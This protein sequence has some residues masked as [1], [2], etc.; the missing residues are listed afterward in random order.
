MMTIKNY[1]RN[2]FRF[3]L[4]MELEERLHTFCMFKTRY[5]LPFEKDEVY[6]FFVNVIDWPKKLPHCN[7]IEIIYDDSENQEFVMEVKTQYG[8]EYFRSIRTCN[9]DTYTISYFQP[10]PPPVLKTHTGSW[11]IHSTEDGTKVISLHTIRINSVICAKLFND[12]NL[13]MNKQRVKELILNNSK[14]TIEA[15]KQW[16]TNKQEIVYA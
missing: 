8:D 11:E 6:D 16:L 2:L 14:I 1:C 10:S 12:T 9:R 4:S 15:C 3:D 5:F 7:S 13:T